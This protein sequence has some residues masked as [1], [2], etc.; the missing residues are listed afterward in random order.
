[1]A[2][3]FCVPLHVKI[4]K[5]KINPITGCWEWQSHKF[6]DGYGKVYYSGKTDRAHRVSYRLHKG[7]IPDGMWVLHNCDNPTCINPEHLHFGTPTENVRE[8]LSRGR[9]RNGK[10]GANGEKNSHAKLTEEQVQLIRSSITRTRLLARQYGVNISTVQRIRNGKAWRGD[11]A[12]IALAAREEFL[13]RSKLQAAQT[14]A[15]QGK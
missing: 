11:A 8:C 13:K 2:N 5:Y 6:R 12:G 9:Y 14:L 3:T 10:C 1:M 15:E 7:E 4:Q